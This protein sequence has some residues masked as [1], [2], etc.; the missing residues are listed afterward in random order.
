M[1]TVMKAFI[2]SEYYIQR[3]IADRKISSGEMGA[4]GFDNSVPTI[5]HIEREGGRGT[6]VIQYWKEWCDPIQDGTGRR[7]RI[8]FQYIG[9][10]WV[11]RRPA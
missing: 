11:D 9:G 3:R 10:L 2:P 7:K 4:H 6:I 1:A 5:V 8:I